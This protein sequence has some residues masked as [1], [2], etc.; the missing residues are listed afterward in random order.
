MSS[1]NEPFDLWSKSLTEELNNPQDDITPTT[2]H[3]P[4]DEPPDVYQDDS[5]L[6]T[7]QNPGDEP[8][9]IYQYGSTLTTVTT[10]KFKLSLASLVSLAVI[11]VAVAFVCMVPES[12]SVD[13]PC[14]NQLYCHRILSLVRQVESFPL[15]LP[16]D[17]SAHGVVLDKLRFPENILSSLVDQHT[18]VCSSLTS[19]SETLVKSLAHT[20]TMYACSDSNHAITSF[21][22]EISTTQKQLNST[23]AEVQILARHYFKISQDYHT[24][25]ASAAEALKAAQLSDFQTTFIWILPSRLMDS[26]DVYSAYILP[27]EGKRRQE[28]ETRLGVTALEREVQGLEL[29]LRVV[30]E[31]EH[32]LRVLAT[33]VSCRG[34]DC[35]WR[36]KELQEWLGEPLFSAHPVRPKLQN[37]AARCGYQ[38]FS[39]G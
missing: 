15:P 3:I 35:V 22:H 38:R 19:T 9:Y 12:L 23:A 4:G 8:L 20:A 2:P 5:T 24:L 30:Q 1:T 29:I 31:L 21:R 6:T 16:V 11:V 27:L 26:I 39:I 18:E 32:N 25:H 34:Q 13:L 17:R 7:P 36:Q 37:E 28:E 33:W 10:W 14:S